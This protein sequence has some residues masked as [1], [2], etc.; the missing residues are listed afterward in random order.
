MNR[1]KEKVVIV[2]GAGRGIGRAIALGF[3][4][5]GAKVIIAD[6]RDK[7]GQETAKLINQ[8][9]GKGLFIHTDVSNKSEVDAMVIKTVET[10]G[11]IDVL[12]N[13]A[14]ICP[15]K[16]F[17][18]I[19]EEM[20][21]HVLEVNLKGVFLC[22]QAAAKVMIDKGIKGKIIS[23]GS[24]SSVVGGAQQAHYC[25]TKAGINLL[26]ASMAIAL[27]PHGITCNAVLPGPI[28]TDINREDLAN[29]T[30]RNYFIQRTPLRRIGQPQ[31]VVGPIMFFASQDADWCTGS[32]LVVDGGILVNFQ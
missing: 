26:T 18:D 19:P 24:I 28:E 12:V 20:W 27:G 29:E 23:V 7:Q 15:F 10:F 14:G 13:D 3:G 11:A 22:S 16:D 4:N 30:K 25:S 17:L 8:A 32:T 5:Q 6:I 31:D 21:D 9:G 2:T 1:F